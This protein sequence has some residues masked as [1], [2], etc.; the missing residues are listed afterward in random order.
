MIRRVNPASGFSHAVVAG[1]TIYLAGQTA[2][3]ADGRI[4][5]GDDIVAQVD[6]ALANLVGALT[7]AGGTPA[8]LVQATIYIVDIPAYRSRGREIGEVWRRRCG[9]DYPAVTAVGVARLWDAEALVEVA[10]I[11]VV[12][13]T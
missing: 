4:A 8:D 1:D 13:S 6:Q 7:A 5:G 9:T 12:P 10:G 2:L 11:A 3:G